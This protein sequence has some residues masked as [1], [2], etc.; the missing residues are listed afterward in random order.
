[1][2]SSA[3]ILTYILIIT[4]L[5]EIKQDKFFVSMATILVFIMWMKQFYFLRLF[6]TTALL[7]RM[8]IDITM[9]I[10]WFLMV[11]LLAIL[12]FG[13][14]FF[15]ISKNLKDEELLGF[16][17][18]PNFMTAFLYSYK[19]SLGD[20]NFKGYE[21]RDVIMVHLLWFFHTWLT[22]II[23][24]NLLIAIMGDTYARVKE[25]EQNNMLKEFCEMITENEM[26]FKRSRLF[27]DKKY[28]FV[29][30]KEKFEKEDD[31]F[32]GKL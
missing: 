27:K 11:M 28:I 5:A 25:N 16:F 4:D 9:E 18:G 20:F 1:M 26:L 15:I 2:D 3:L 19:N 13:N 8:I 29:V 22:L 30:E 21:Y 17:V 32:E 24:L 7:V 10:K 14:S 6:P 23:L 31:S 12:G